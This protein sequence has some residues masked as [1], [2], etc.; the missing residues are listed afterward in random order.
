MR[1]HVA[2]IDPG[3]NHPELGCFNQFVLRYSDLSWSYH[4]PALAG[5][6]SL[7]L[8]GEPDA[9]VIL[10]SA[11]SVEDELEWQDEF[12]EF[13]KGMIENE[14]PIFGLCYAHQLIADMYGARV[15]L[16]QK[17]G[18]KFKGLR[19]VEFVS[20][21][22]EGSESCD[23]VV[24]H[25]EAVLECPD[26][27]E[28]WAK[29]SFIEIEGLYHKE[30]PIWTLQSHPEA[31]QGFLENQEILL[32]KPLPDDGWQLIDLFIRNIVQKRQ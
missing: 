30:R 28:V 21:Q 2:V 25:R 11:A 18:E 5:L 27:F 32:E 7:D 23:L 3:M 1:Q 24:S 26:G 15:G 14:I 10:G 20:P 16:A 19:R 29:S 6:S 17:S 8:A 9:L 4:L 12:R 31:E 13:L 22:F